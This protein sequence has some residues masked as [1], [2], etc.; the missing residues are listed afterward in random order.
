MPFD[1]LI[2][3]GLLV[4]GTGSAARPADVGVLGDRI[5]AIGDLSAVE[6][7]DVALVV[8]VRGLVV[9]PGFID[10]HGHSD[11][12][13]FVDGMLASHLRQG[14]TTQVSGNC[15]FS[16]APLTPIGRAGIDIEL[17]ALRL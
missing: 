15:G 4:D 9:T 8:D 13:L 10:P 17:A 3:G 16:L 1:L 11:G 5:L 7:G 12:T 2:R 6:T 14:F